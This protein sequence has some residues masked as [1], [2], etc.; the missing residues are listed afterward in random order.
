MIICK[1]WLFFKTD[2]QTKLIIDTAALFNNKRKPWE[3]ISVLFSGNVYQ[4]KFSR[5]V[6][7][8][9]KL[10]N[11]HFK[12]VRRTK[13]NIDTVALFNNKESRGR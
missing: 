7:I 13:L 1:T 8:I 9:Q 6:K 10:S 5:T 4:I 12:L 2:R 3:M 11:S